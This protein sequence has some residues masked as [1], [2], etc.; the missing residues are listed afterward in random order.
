MDDP[1]DAILIVEDE[2]LIRY[3]L[4]DFFEDAGF[5]VFE[6]DNAEVAIALMDANRSIRIVL[7]DVQMPGTMDGM[8]LAHHIRDRYPPTL[9]LIASGE[10]RPTA[11]ELPTGAVFI[12]KPFDPRSVL[13]VIQQAF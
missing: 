4:V 8:K 6:A 11:A 10:I 7:T 9:L 1:G 3:D 12:Q 2:A 13:S 5:Q